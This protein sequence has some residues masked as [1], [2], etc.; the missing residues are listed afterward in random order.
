ME[1]AMH[2]IWLGV[3]VVF[4]VVG[5]I[6]LR[7]VDGFKRPIP[8]AL[9]VAGYGIAFYCLTHILK[10]IPVG[11]TYA[12]WSGAG[13]ALV[14]IVGWL[15]LKQVLDVASVIGIAMII[16]GVVVMRLFSKTMVL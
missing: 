4:E 12:I 14:V 1:Q 10:V 16:G 11:I 8:L 2:W 6:A 13:S 5:T 9:V 3:A 15:W 7:E